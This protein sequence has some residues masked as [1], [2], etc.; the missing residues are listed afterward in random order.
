MPLQIF[1]VFAKAIHSTLKEIS[2]SSGYVVQRPGGT[3]FKWV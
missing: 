1:D 2:T 3:S